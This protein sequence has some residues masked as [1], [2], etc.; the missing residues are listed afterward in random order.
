MTY[1]R[2]NALRALPVGGAVFVVFVAILVVPQV[3]ISATASTVAFLLPFLAA[4]VCAVGVRAVLGPI[5][6]AI[7][8]ITR[9]HA[10][11]P[12][13]VLAEAAGRIR[14]GELDTALPGLAKVLVDGTAARR[15]GIW[16]V[17]ADTLVAAAV[18]PAAD[19]P[20]PDAANLAVLLDRPDVD[21]VMPVVDGEVLRAA[22]TLD[23]S[24]APV[25][26]ADRQLLRDVASG[27]RLLLR[28]IALNAE[29][30][31]RVRQAANLGAELN[32]S[33]SRLA[34]ARAVER[35]RLAAE[36]AHAA[37]GR[38]AEVRAGLED[39]RD[40]I[41]AQRSEEA[42]AGL[43]QVRVGLDEIIERFRSVARGVYPA[44]LRDHGPS[45]A[46][47]ELIIDLPRRVDLRGST[48]RRLQWEV[49]SGV[50]YVA[51]SALHCLAERPG[52]PIRVTFDHTDGRLSVEIVDP[53]PKVSADGLRAELANDL[54]RLAALGG[55][56]HF[57]RDGSAIV[58]A[59]SL[60]ERLEPL[61]EVSP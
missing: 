29:L 33:R 18:Y 3:L 28:G 4:A 6:L 27:A 20:L 45:A 16:V 46:L 31:E 9:R 48:S 55:S 22:L 49:E 17:S 35:R 50:Y 1:L 53:R 51:A 47:E 12:Y 41:L 23:K 57:G 7:E 2:M 5:D 42:V 61:V 8:R 15:A 52:P 37:T 39:V 54:E 40:D 59:A 60:P 14:S 38:L 36:L 10:A 24:G 21:H 44:V 25:T 56:V 19:A 32:R 43:V 58:L 26:A 13:S 11:T 34:R 30:R